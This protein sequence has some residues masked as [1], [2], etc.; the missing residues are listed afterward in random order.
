MA[1]SLQPDFEYASSRFVFQSQAV[2]SA[3]AVSI[4]ANSSFIKVYN[5]D[6]R[7]NAWISKGYPIEK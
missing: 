4:L 6:S 5:L 3:L 1:V 2:P 7:V